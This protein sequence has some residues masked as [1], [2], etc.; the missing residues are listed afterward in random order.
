M[1]NPIKVWRNQRKTRGSLGLEG[2]VITWTKIFVA[3]SDFKDYTPYPVVLVAM[4]DGSKLYGQ[5]VDYNEAHLAIGQ[6][7]VSVLRLAKKSTAE[8]I[9]E[10]GVK[11]R[12]K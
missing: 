4:N 3:P 12:P 5:L 1:A 9:V 10:Y 2:T 11:F 7:V 8:E 6:K